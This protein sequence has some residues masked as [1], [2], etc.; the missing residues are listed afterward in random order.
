MLDTPR[1]EWDRCDLFYHG[2]GIEVK[3]SAY[4]QS[5]YQERPSKIQFDIAKK[6]RWDSTTNTY[7]PD[8]PCRCADCYV[9]CLFTGE[10][11]RHEDVLD[12]SL[13]KFYVLATDVIEEQFGEQKSVALSRIEEV[14]EAV[15]YGDL[16]H[17]VDSVFGVE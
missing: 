2:A 6:L 12:T 10:E 13:W 5:W 3:S 4:V 16:K 15:S 14:C 17:M 8:D 9:F 1:I 11:E 7:V